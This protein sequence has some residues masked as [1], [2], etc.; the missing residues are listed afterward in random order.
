MPPATRL[1]LS[2]PLA[3]CLLFTTYNGFVEGFNMTHYWGTP[4]MKVATAFQLA[5][6]VLGAVGLF[7]LVRRPRWSGAVLLGW[8]VAVTL[9]GCLL[10][11]STRVSRS[12]TESWQPR[13]W[14]RLP[15]ARG[16]GGRVLAVSPSLPRGREFER[17][18][19]TAE[20]SRS[21]LM[22]AVAHELRVTNR[23][24]NMTPSSRR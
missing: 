3:S 22:K 9:R 6:G 12:R 1:L 24:R 18:V 21:A 2:A 17:A 7:V 16:G 10:R 5:Y 20:A 19:T 8:C 11:L 13:S 4:G 14:Q 23:C 15:A